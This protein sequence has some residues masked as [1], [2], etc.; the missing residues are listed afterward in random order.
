[1][2]DQPDGGRHANELTLTAV[3][4]GRGGEIDLD[5]NFDPSLKP[6]EIVAGRYEVAISNPTEGFSWIG[7]VNPEGYVVEGTMA[8]H[9][10]C[11]LA[12]AFVDGEFPD[13]G[14]G[15]LM[16]EGRRATLV[17]TVGEETYCYTA[18][19]W[20][21]SVSFPVMAPGAFDYH[22]IV[23]NDDTGF[24]WEGDVD[25]AEHLTQTA[26]YCRLPVM[27]SSAEGGA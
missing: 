15:D 13:L 25:D 16:W 21:T 7:G 12:V 8:V 17:G 2:A 20:M 18:E 19:S 3:R 24:V 4:P 26:A 5:I 22:V 1:M 27:S 14:V 11:E 9:A 6:G 23:E 10:A